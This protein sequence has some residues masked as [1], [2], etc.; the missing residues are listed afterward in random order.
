MSG[1]HDK[2]ARLQNYTLRVKSQ[3][4]LLDHDLFPAASR[5][6][7]LN[8]PRQ[9]GLNNFIMIHKLQ[10]AQA[11]NLVILSSCHPALLLSCTLV[12][13]RACQFSS[14]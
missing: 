5:P 9:S 12:I 7:P 8:L 11:Q 4:L 3:A 14:L 6:L 1:D 2:I 10:D 13:L